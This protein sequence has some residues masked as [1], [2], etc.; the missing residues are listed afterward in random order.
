MNKTIK[1]LPLLAASAVV[2]GCQDYDLGIN[3]DEV[4]YKESFT[5][6]FGQIDPN[7]NWD[8]Y[9]QL[10]ADQGGM[11]RAAVPTPVLGSVDVSNLP[12]SQY[13]YLTKEEAM[14]YQKMLP[15]SEAQA[16][17]YG[18]TNLGRVVQNFKVKTKS[19]VLYPVHWNTSG[20]DVVG[21]YYHVPAGTT[22]ENVEEI[23]GIDGK[24]Y[25]IAKVKLYDNKTHLY[26][27]SQDAEN[28][29]VWFN[30]TEAHDFVMSYW[31]QLVAHNPTRYFADNGTKKVLVDATAHDFNEYYANSSYAT[32]LWNDL[33]EIDP[34]T[35]QI[36]DGTVVT[37]WGY[38]T[39]EGDKMVF[40][41]ANRTW[42]PVTSQNALSV[43][44]FGT[45]AKMLQSRGIIVTL[46]ETAEI[47]MY[48]TNNGATT[49]THT[50]YSESN[51]NYTVDW[52]GSVGVKEACF[53]A[54]YID[55][56]KDNQPIKDNDGNDVRYLCFEDWH[57][58]KNFD[59]ND[60]IFR[61]YGFDGPGSEVVDFDEEMEE[62]LLVCEDLGNFDFDF[63]DVVL[64][65]GYKKTITRETHYKN[66]TDEVEFVTMTN[67]ESIYV[68]PM[69]AGG[70]NESTIKI[71][72]VG[73]DGKAD[74]SLGEIHALLNGSAPT[75]INAGST[76][77]S[78]GTEVS[79][80]AATYGCG[81]KGSYPTYLSKLFAEDFIQITTVGGNVIKKT[82]GTD[83]K[84]GM[85]STPTMLL[86]PMSFE[87]PTE[88]TLICDAYPGFKDWVENADATGWISGKDDS[89]VTK[90]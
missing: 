1:F 33:V 62:A 71:H 83:Y 27:T 45:P 9:G 43:W 79:M 28:T 73:G 70:A 30:S 87:W 7:Q 85:A 24:T 65:L 35:F 54:T 29:I 58:V 48:L 60:V 49:G 61:V 3:V 59:L 25:T 84:K 64:K 22:G 15:E 21:L 38:G 56:D 20:N 44:T 40:M 77:G 74:Y 78:A 12:E 18:E 66:G 88:S 5:K 16:A 67:H 69:A 19:F 90:R 13:A 39:N 89:K 36:S 46:P 8:L 4:R 23:T 10:A 52:G 17:P 47:G 41:P 32:L 51:L 55:K 63:N 82:T 76:F 53:V 80:S 14:R 2:V 6:A 34:T 86:L 42:N 26:Y 11:T 81:N 68:T 75:I 50:F 57:G 37:T 31:D 72:A